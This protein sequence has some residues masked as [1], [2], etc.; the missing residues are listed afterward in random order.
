LLVRYSI[1]LARLHFGSLLR[2]IA[3]SLQFGEGAPRL[4]SEERARHTV[5]RATDACSPER[6]SSEPESLRPPEFRALPPRL[7]AVVAPHYRHCF[8]N[9]PRCPLR[10][11]GEW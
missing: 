1:G 2:S 8:S 4:V 9:L 5:T 10:R 7:T 11:H 3:K 6:P